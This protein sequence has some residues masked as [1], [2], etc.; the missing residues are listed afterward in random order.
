MLASE[1]TALTELKPNTFSVPELSTVSCKLSVL[2]FPDILSIVPASA[3][4][5]FESEVS[6]L[7]NVIVSDNSS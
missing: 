3:M 4:L 1:S 7:S 2:V 6:V 5:T